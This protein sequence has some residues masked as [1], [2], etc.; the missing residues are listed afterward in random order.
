MITLDRPWF[1]G[2]T[3]FLRADGNSAVRLPSPPVPL[4]PTDARPAAELIKYRYPPNEGEDEVGGG[5]LRLLLD[6]GAPLPAL[7]ACEAE[8]PADVELP[9]AQP[10]LA[11]GVVKLWS[12]ETE[13][14]RSNVP[15]GRRPLV[16]FAAGISPDLA[17]L[18]EEAGRNGSPALHATVEAGIPVAEGPG[19]QIEIDLGRAR[20]GVGG[21]RSVT[22]AEG[23]GTIAHLIESGVVRLTV[24]AISPVVPEATRLLCA[25][26]VAGRL[27]EPAADE[28]PWSLLPGL[29]S[30]GYVPRGRLRPRSGLGDGTVTLTVGAGEETVVPWF[31]AAPIVIRPDCVQLADLPS[32][33]VVG[34]QVVLTGPVP[35]GSAG[36]SVEI[37]CGGKTREA[38]FESGAGDV[39]QARVLRFVP[40]PGWEGAYRSR[41]KVARKDG[42]SVSGEWRAGTNRILVIVP[43]E[44]ETLLVSRAG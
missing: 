35:E 36:L 40:P 34:V 3:L 26:L 41:L 38:V 8:L 14:G 33:S 4:A 1:A 10:V 23:A 37:D 22:A 9:V 12:G 27:Y 11:P 25:A 42:T 43:Q 19:T 20:A 5:I 2:E 21:A 17:T 32:S 44:T 7:D 16:P 24:D 28:E 6:L 29:A 18:V 31:G 30:P 15:A 39:T 13:L